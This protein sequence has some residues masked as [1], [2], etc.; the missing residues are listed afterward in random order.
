[1]TAD[2]LRKKLKLKDGGDTYI[3]GTTVDNRA[4][5]EIWK[6]KSGPVLVIAKKT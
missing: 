3:F 4:F 6:V 1:M 2:V 5:A